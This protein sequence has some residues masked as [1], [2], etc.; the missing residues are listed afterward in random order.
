MVWAPGRQW[1]LVVGGVD[2]SEELTEK[3]GAFAVAGCEEY[4]FLGGLNG[5]GESGCPGTG[6]VEVGVAYDAALLE[7]WLGLAG[8]GKAHEHD[9]SVVDSDGG[10]GEGDVGDGGGGDI[11]G[12]GLEGW[13]GDED[14]GVVD[15]GVAGVK[16]VAVTP[17][18]AVDAGQVDGVSEGSFFWLLGGP[19][20]PGCTLFG[21]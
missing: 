7:V 11:D 20:V 13:G 9:E 15:T 3:A 16:D 12:E 6:L 1:F 14:G 21:G 5:E 4:D 17:D 10:Y 18:K 8:L 19:G 2:C